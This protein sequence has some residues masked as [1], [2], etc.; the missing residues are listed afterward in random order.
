MSRNLLKEESEHPLADAFDNE[1]SGRGDGFIL[2]CI[3]LFVCL[4]VF[5]CVQ[6]VV[7]H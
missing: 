2:A 5:L 4:S 7:I 1:A 6:F 3:V